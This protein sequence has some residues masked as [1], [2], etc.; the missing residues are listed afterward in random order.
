MSVDSWSVA[1]LRCKADKTGNS[2]LDLYDFVKGIEGV[3][4]RADTPPI[5]LIRRSLF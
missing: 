1:V 5:S 3:S 4:A 2:L